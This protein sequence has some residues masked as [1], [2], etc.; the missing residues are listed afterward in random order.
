MADQQTLRLG[1]VARKFNVGI[2]TIIEHLGSKG[3][4]IE[5]NPNSKITKEQF[6]IL[7]IEFASSLL[8]KEEASSLSIGAKSENIIIEKSSEEMHWR[9]ED[10]DEIFIKNLSLD[11]VVEEKEPDVKIEKISEESPEGR[12]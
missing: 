1:Q 4:E 11:D 6:D 9:K 3:Q 10:D 5:S 12:E 2:G 8:E 7:A